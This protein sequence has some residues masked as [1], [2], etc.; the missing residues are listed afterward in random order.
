MTRTGEF[1]KTRLHF[2]KLL[3]KDDS[4][5]LFREKPL[6]VAIVA[7]VASFVNDAFAPFKEEVSLYVFSVRT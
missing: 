6:H 2:T 4:F 3:N 5:V 7:V 1:I